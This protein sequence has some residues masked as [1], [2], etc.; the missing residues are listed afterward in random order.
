MKSGF[1]HAQNQGKGAAVRR[2]LAAATGDI[3]LVQDADLEY[4]PADYPLLLE[5]IIAGRADVVYGSRFREESE[6]WWWRQWVAN[7]TLTWLS[8]RMTGWR[9]TDM[10]T[11]YKVFRRRWS[12]ASGWRAI[13]LA[14]NPR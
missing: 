9:V 5:P 12:R 10:E 13:V 11:C 6:G 14:L 8:N 3:I 2:G 4:D 7:R 1:F